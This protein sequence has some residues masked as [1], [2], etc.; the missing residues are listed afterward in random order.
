MEDD[1]SGRQARSRSRSVPAIFHVRGTAEALRDASHAALWSPRSEPKVAASLYLSQRQ[2]LQWFGGQAH[3]ILE[4]RDHWSAVVLSRRSR[5]PS[6]SMACRT[7]H[8]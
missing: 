1:S 7:T 4:T 6:A 8:G 3:R 5:P 2:T